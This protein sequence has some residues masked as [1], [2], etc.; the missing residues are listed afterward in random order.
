MLSLKPDTRKKFI[1]IR[2]AADAALH[3]KV[4]ANLKT[5]LDTLIKENNR[6]VI[7]AYLPIKEEICLRQILKWLTEIGMPYTLPKIINYE[8]R[9][10]VFVPHTLSDTLCQNRFGISEPVGDVETEP[11]LL[12]VPALAVDLQGTRLGYGHG[13]YDRYIHKLRCKNKPLIVIAP[14][15][16][17]QIHA[18]ILPKEAHDQSVNFIVT[19]QRIHKC[20]QNS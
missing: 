9:E 11:D 13:Y 14:C 6:R 12:I 17:A 1:A 16:E 20:I 2:K 4:E 8:K 7:G 3:R 18:N 5:L 10:M 15:L 19:E